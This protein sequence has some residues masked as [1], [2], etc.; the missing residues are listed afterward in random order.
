LEA[1][2]AQGNALH[3]RERDPWTGRQDELEA[4]FRTISAQRIPQWQCVPMP[5]SIRAAKKLMN[6]AAR[7]QF[8]LREM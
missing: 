5:S 7:P 2:P 4:V 3:F 8:R 6:L 1:L